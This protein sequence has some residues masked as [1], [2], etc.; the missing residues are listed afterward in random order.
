MKAYLAL[1]C[2]IFLIGSI[3][4]QDNP[5]KQGFVP[6][7]ATAVRVAEAVLIPV[8]GEKKIHSERPF[9]ASLENEVWTVR[10]TLH[11][12][13]GKGGT[14]THCVGGTAEVQISKM[15]G[16]IIRVAHYK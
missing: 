8:Y 16:H 12:S 13:G 6:D 7:S 1:C 15:D 9:I 5:P 2:S 3:G 10:G 4:A 14:S 11:C